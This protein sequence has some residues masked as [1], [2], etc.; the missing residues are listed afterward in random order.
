[1]ANWRRVLVVIIAAVVAWAIAL[2]TGRRLAY[3]LAYVLTALL[4]AAFTI[5][6]T[7][8]RGIGLTRV[9]PSRRSQVG[10]VVEEHLAV[11]N[12]WWLPK[13]WLEVRD[14]STLPGHRVSHVVPSLPARRTYRWHVRTLAIRRGVFR[15]GPMRL[16]STDPFGLFTF[17]RD[18][19][20]HTAIVIYPYVAALHHFPLPEGRLPGGGAAFRRTHQV[21]TNVSGVRDYQPGDALNRIHWPTTARVRRLMAKEFE[22]D[23]L[24]DVW[25]VVDMHRDVYGGRR[26]EEEALPPVLA[27]DRP[28]ILLPPHAAEYAIAAAATL[29][30]YMLRQNRALGLVSHA[31][32][33]WVLPADR[34]ERQRDRLLETLAMVEPE[35][36]L[37]LD[38]LLLSE[39]RLF[40]RHTT[41]VVIT[42]DWTAR[43]VPP[44]AELKR[45]SVLPIVVLVDGSTFTH[46]PGPDTALVNLARQNILTFVLRNGTPL[47]QALTHPV[48]KARL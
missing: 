9:T 35:G 27:L 4:G 28:D 33:R 36:T 5:A 43:W 10:H 45:R 2:H 6:W 24:A 32:R 13:L 3:Q 41:L 23:P 18:I 21:T 7:G 26:P 19:P 17:H 16:R 22:L 15:L 25:L 40:G 29:G 11:H 1:M 44:L 31:Q 34:G 37:P 39:L 8:V 30:T 38:H 42:G 48:V 20:R 46:V 12:R 14:F 47:T